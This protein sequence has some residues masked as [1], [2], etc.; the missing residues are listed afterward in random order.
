ME[1]SSLFWQTYLNLEKELLEVAK[2]IYVTD[3]VSTY[4]KGTI[5]TSPCKTQ[6]STFSPHIA[7][8]LVRT[9]IEIEA[10]SKELYFRFGGQKAR[11]D[12]DLFFDEDCL[13][14]IDIKCN[15]HK[16]VVIVSCALF[17]LT[18]E[19]N[20]Y[21]RPLREAHKRQGTDWE[22]AYQAVKHDRYSSI[23]QG[24]IKNLLHAMG[25]LYL[26][27]I[28]YKSAKMSAK[29]LDVHNLDFSLG[30]SVFSV[31]QPSHEYVISIINN[32][33]ITDILH[34][35]ESPFVLKYTDSYYRQIL[36][37]NKTML[38][39]MNSYWLSQPELQEPEFIHQMM[40]AKQKEDRDPSQR[41]IPLWELAK[42]RL[43]KKIP[44]SLPFEE[45][46]KLFI[47]TPEWNGQI[48]QKNSH[49]N[50]DEIT[51]ANIQSE[52]DY[53][54]VL[55][56]MELQERFERMKMYKAFN[57]GYCDLILDTGDVRY[58]K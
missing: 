36:D 44:A 26:L 1:K 45:R 42:Y 18:E 5:I 7:D 47:S 19:E 50:A 49:L 39:E 2:Y 34:S 57:E 35:D 37:T 17:N 13:K 20:L 55:A 23:S 24:T 40:Q 8:L 32:Q 29:Y 3:V 6:L 43:R 52:I 53:A 21:F 54:G 27:N 14:T 56:G 15:T 46:K 28:Y 58:I 30:S 10:I 12:K 38:E 41:L 22:K 33:D 4:S 9:C 48:R 11:G 16:K 51:E 25:A 31:K